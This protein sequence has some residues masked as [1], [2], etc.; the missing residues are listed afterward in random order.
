MV[1]SLICQVLTP[2]TNAGF[3]I[4][5]APSPPPPRRREPERQTKETDI[6]IYTSRNNTE[7]DITKTIS[8]TRTPQPV[9]E[10]V[11]E[12]RRENFYDDSVIYEQER[13]K[14][15]V[16]DTQLELSRRRSVSARPPPPREKSRVRVD[17]RDDEEEA[18]YYA[19]KVN[20]RAFI[21][22][23][24]NGATK[25]WAIVDVPP[26]TERV[27]MDGIG[28]A[29]EEITWQKYNGVRRSKFIPERERAAPVERERERVEIREEIREEPKRESIS[30]TSL[31][32][33]I[34][35]GGGRRERE[36][37]GTTYER[38]Y[39]RIEEVSDRRVGLP[40]APPKQRMGDLWTEIT[41]DLVS[42]EAIE[43][44]GYDFEET[45]FFYYIIQYLRYVSHHV[46]ISLMY[47]F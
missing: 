44:L 3:E 32:I 18:D 45:E 47:R 24:Y 12:S 13:D 35:T 20:E 9:R 8:R 29:S 11:R 16:R 31:E 38:D 42:R 1:F 28:G 43:Q 34:H 22:E 39:E 25:D 41:K 30:S 19:R 6:D 27:R 37:G 14:L 2:L 33:D 15:R 23:A 21:G 40:R 36:R 46:R 7:V 10:P 4:A 26:G 5:H 17:I